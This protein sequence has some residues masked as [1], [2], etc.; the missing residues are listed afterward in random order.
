MFTNAL[1]QTILDVE[2]PHDSSDA[3]VTFTEVNAAGQTVFIAHPTAVSGYDESLADLVGLVSDPFTGDN[4]TYIRD[5]EGLVETL[6]F[7]TAGG[8]AANGATIGD[9]GLV[10]GWTEFW[11][12]HNGELG[13]GQKR[14]EYEYRL[15][16]VGGEDIVYNSKQTEYR[17]ASVG[18]SDP[19]TTSFIN[20]YHSGTFAVESTTVTRPT[21]ATSQNGPNSAS[22]EVT[23]FDVYGRPIW[24][25]DADGFLAYSDYD[26][27]TGGVAKQIVDVDTTQTGDFSHLPSGWS[28][29]GTGGLHLSSTFGFDALGRTVEA[30]DP[31]GKATYTIYDDADQEVRVYV[32]WDAS[33]NGGSGGPTG[34]TIV[35][36]HDRA[37]GYTETLRMSAAPAV[38][39][40]RPTGTESIS[41]VES[42]SREHYNAAWQKVASD[43]YFD[44]SG[45]S[46][47][48]LASLGTEGTHY[49]RTAFAYDDLGDVRR[50][51]D[52]TGTI[53]RYVRDGLR[54]VTSQWIGTD[55][56]PTSG[57]WS[58]DNTTG[59]DMLPVVEYEY[60]HGGVGNS[61]IT[62]ETRPVDANSA[63]DRITLYD[64]DFRNRLVLIRGGVSISGSNATA[65]EH[66]YY[67]YDNLDRVTQTERF[68]AD[69]NPTAWAYQDGAPKDPANVSG[70]PKRTHQAGTSLDDEGRVYQARTYSVNPSTGAVS[71]GLITNYWRDRR[72]NVIK[73][74]APGGLV[75]KRA[76]DGANRLT[77]TSLTDG[78]G[79]P[80]PGAS[81]NWSHADDVTGD[82]VLEEYAH[83]YDGAS[84][85]IFSTTK[86]RHHDATGT[87][88][89]GDATTGPRARVSYEAFYF[90]NANRL[91]D[92]VFVGTNGGS[93]Y[94]R[95]STVPGRSDTVLIDSTT[96]SDAGW[97]FSTVDPRGIETRF[98]HD[99]LGRRITLIEA[100]VDGT[101]SDGDDRT[102]RWTHDGNGNVLSMTADLP[103]GQ[104]DQTT[105]YDHQARTSRGDAI[106]RNDLLIST[107]YPD[108]GGSVERTESYTSNRAGQ[109][110][111]WTDRNGTEHEY[112]LDVLGRVTSDLVTA[113]G[114]GVDGAVQEITVSYDDAGRVYELTS[115]DGG[116]SV[117]NQIR[118]T[119][120]GLGQ[121]SREFQE[122]DGAVDS[123]TLYVGYTWGTSAQGSRL[124]GIVYPKRDG[125]PLGGD[126]QLTYFYDSGLD[127]TIS[128]LSSIGQEGDLMT[129]PPEPPTYFEVYDY[130]GLATV[131]ARRHPEADVDLVYYSET[132][133]TGDAG[134]QYVGLARFGRI[135]DQRWVDS[136]SSWVDVDR[137]QYGHDRN[138]NRLYEENLLESSLSEL[139]HDG[140]GYDKLDRLTTFERGTLNANKD[141]LTGTADRGQYWTLDA[142]GNWSSVANET[143]GFGTLQTR[144][145]DDQNRISSVS[146]ASSPTYSPNGEMLSDETG[147]VLAYDAWGRLM[148]V[149]VDADSVV[150][151]AYAYDALNRK[152]LVDEGNGEKAWYYTQEWQVLEERDAVSGDVEVQYVW[153]PVYVDAMVLRDRDTDADGDTQD[154]GGSERLYVL[155]DANFNVTALTDV[156]G[157]VQ[158]RFLYDPYGER[159]VLN[160]D[161]TVDTDGLSDFTFVHGHQGGRHDLATGLVDFRNR[162]LDTSLG[163]WERQDPAGYVDGAN[164]FV[165]YTSA[166]LNYVDANGFSATSPTTQPTT[167]PSTRPTTR[168]QLE[169][170][171]VEPEPFDEAPDDEPNPYEKN[172][173]Y[174]VGPFDV[175][176]LGTVTGKEAAAVVKSLEALDET[177]EGRKILEE[178]GKGQRPE[179]VVGPDKDNKGHGSRRR[180]EINPTLEHRREHNMITVRDL[181]DGTLFGTRKRVVPSVYRAVVH[182]CAHGVLG[183]PG[184]PEGERQAL[185]VEER[186]CE[187]IG[188]NRREGYR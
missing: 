24:F 177:E 30:T 58:P 183:I 82:V 168:P 80:N 180:I 84:N 40:G 81:N 77:R 38:S 123:S 182:E 2:R 115:L 16:T 42:L 186:A 90:D 20:T 48:T 156:A 99:A 143:G 25:K 97:V 11:S 167:R 36:R 91:T 32:G 7:A 119:Y 129:F 108:V 142:L 162:H 96:Y 79:D 92:S 141:D 67:T 188:M 117:V 64:H 5:D 106:N 160:A 146:G 10:E 155:H 75:T 187:Q 52:P 176:G 112:S 137:Y 174:P 147:Q 44:L 149:D 83:A 68:G 46:Y 138:G 173:S 148:A 105:T 179:V 65:L 51:E 157:I 151:V 121:V 28:T 22:S 9:D 1:G 102:T 127:A 164:L 171:G 122:H 185:E 101:P 136:S 37:G 169:D 113:L 13:N 130:L 47:T 53:T 21:V 93:S 100:Y 57:F 26:V 89:L 15:Q 23:F 114:S 55:D 76:F 181:D 6:G 111:S 35:R 45:L 161:W 133:T 12:Y 128:R 165:A 163:R 125:G 110:I 39:G 69:T 14:I 152:V 8:A 132:G 33:L 103:S 87:G 116:S 27:T 3:W 50:I 154:A 63:N 4:R 158:E 131:V 61:L 62:R 98:E 166:P 60:D 135:A 66:F 140:S 153:S 78:G 41:S 120:N 172:K 139:Y 56:T 74:K 145:H 118:R 73:E 175:K 159:T 94:S 34:P 134:D 19:Q 54:R 178:A 124:T 59:A 71:S 144:T 18:G 43:E 184:G 72:G 104:S 95:P 107:T 88:A 17:V 29:P 31:E 170:G 70:G 49:Y 150:D 109:R 86:L 126:R 85:P